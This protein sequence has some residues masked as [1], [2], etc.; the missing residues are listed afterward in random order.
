MYFYSSKTFFGNSYSS[1]MPDFRIT[2]YTSHILD[3]PGFLESTAFS[4][5]G[6]NETVMVLQL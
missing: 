1:P 3:I 2:E 6:P 5:N 4:Q